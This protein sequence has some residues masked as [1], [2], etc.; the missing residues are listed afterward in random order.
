MKNICIY[1]SELAIITG[2]NRYEDVGEL[3]LKMWKRNFPD[4]YKVCMD[5]VSLD[6]NLEIK[7]ETP[8]EFLEHISKKNNIKNVSQNLGECLNSSNVED[9]RTKQ[10]TLLKQF[11]NLD[12]PQKQLVKDC[13][14]KKT[15]TNFG[16]K[17]ENSAIVKYMEQSGDTV[18]TINKFFKKDLFRTKNNLWS[19]GGKIDGIIHNDESKILVE[20]KNRVKKLFYNVRD[21]EKVQILTYMNI[22]DLKE[23]KLIESLKKDLDCDINIIDIEF[24]SIFWKHEVEDR[25]EKF[26]KRFEKIMKDETKK[27]KLI[28]ELFITDS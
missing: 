19:I 20:V 24:D 9:L 21:Y 4:D 1:A 6:L 2:H 27:I 12:K 26:I 3:I 22:L 16:T 15:N 13:I 23:A 28:Q 17:Y 18:N 11:D 25:L 10:K 8:E 7:E 14:I 5:K